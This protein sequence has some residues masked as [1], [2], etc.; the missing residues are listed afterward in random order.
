MPYNTRA[1]LQDRLPLG[2]KAKSE[3]NLSRTTNW[4]LLLRLAGSFEQ[5]AKEITLRLSPSPFLRAVIVEVDA[6]AT[7][8]PV[9]LLALPP[10]A[11]EEGK[12]RHDAEQTST[13]DEKE[14]SPG[15]QV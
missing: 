1:N 10:R 13:D 6:D 7:V 12:G 2:N 4:P 11:F 15:H 14:N 5:A 9:N 8:T 3:S